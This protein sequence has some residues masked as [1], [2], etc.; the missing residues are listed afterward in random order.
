MVPAFLQQSQH[1]IHDGEAHSK[2]TGVDYVGEFDG[3]LD[4]EDG[5]V[6]PNDIPIALLGVELD[7]EAADITD[8]IRRTP[9]AQNGREAYKDRGGA[10]S[11][12]EDASR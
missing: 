11:V 6:V 4:E 7:S 8:G 10:A 3:F 2:P 1:R 12:V 5:N 9:R